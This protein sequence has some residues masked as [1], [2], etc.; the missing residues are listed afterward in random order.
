[1]RSGFPNMLRSI[2]RMHAY[3]YIWRGHYK[4]YNN[5]NKHA[6]TKILEIVPTHAPTEILEV[7][8]T[9]HDLL[10]WHLF[11]CHRAPP[12]STMTWCRP[13]SP[14]LEAR[15]TKNDG[16]RRWGSW[17]WRSP[18]R[19]VK[20]LVDTFEWLLSLGDGGGGPTV[21]GGEGRTRQPRQQWCCCLAVPIHSTTH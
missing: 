2:G 1:M 7:V 8:A 15:W 4:L 3:P 9:T 17:W 5:G 19:A 6:P 14:T 11:V 13:S 20:Y 18:V 21:Q 16:S 12:R 10:I